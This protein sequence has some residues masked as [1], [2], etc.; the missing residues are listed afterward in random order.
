MLLDKHNPTVWIIEVLEVVFCHDDL[1]GR[2][3]EIIITFSKDFL[4]TGM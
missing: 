1:T 2:V 3:I 4:K